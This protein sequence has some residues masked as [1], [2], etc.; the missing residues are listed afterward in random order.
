L[1][2]NAAGRFAATEMADDG[3]LAIVLVRRKGSTKARTYPETSK[4]FGN[5]IATLV[6]TTSPC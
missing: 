4:K 1:T 6:R 3:D 2:L 5:A